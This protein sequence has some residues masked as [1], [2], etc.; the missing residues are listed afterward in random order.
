MQYSIE[1]HWHMDI[2]I[3][4]TRL[5]DCHNWFSA[6][7]PCKLLAGCSI[8][9]QSL[10][11]QQQQQQQQQQQHEQQQQ[12]QT[13]QTQTVQTVSGAT[14]LWQETYQLLCT[15]FGLQRK[16]TVFWCSAGWLVSSCYVYECWLCKIMDLDTC[17]WIFCAHKLNVS[18]CVL[19]FGFFRVCIE[20]WPDCFRVCTLHHVFQSVCIESWPV[21]ADCFRV[22]ALSHDQSADCFRVCALSHDQC[23]LIVSECVHW[24]MTSVCWLC[25]SVCIESWPVFADC[26]RVG[27]VS[28]WPMFYVTIPKANT[29]GRTFSCLLFRS[30]T[31]VMKWSCLSFWQTIC[32]ALS[33]THLPLSQV[34][35]RWETVVFYIAWKWVLLYLGSFSYTRVYLIWVWCK[36]PCSLCYFCFIMHFVHLFRRILCDSCVW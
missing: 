1:F 30:G 11:R 8:V 27:V 12:Q 28:S 14:A 7:I 34:S 13:K 17:E 6:K 2:A 3:I 19:C 16:S 22:C 26:F 5:Y 23:L 9:E 4:V 18:D 32:S 15:F 20:P 24:V 21:F 33:S 10:C 29:A 31:E 35:W 36:I 25:Q